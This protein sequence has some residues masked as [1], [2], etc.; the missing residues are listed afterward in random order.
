MDKSHCGSRNPL[1]LSFESPFLRRCILAAYWLL[2]LLAVPAWWRTTSIERLSLP[3]SQVLKQA[4]REIEFPLEIHLSSSVNGV[5]TGALARE[6]E[7]TLEHRLSRRL[8]VIPHGPEDI[9]VSSE[10]GSYWVKLTQDVRQS[11]IENE[12]L[13]HPWDIHDPIASSALTNSLAALLSP[14]TEQAHAEEREHVVSKYA[15]RFRIAF[16]LLNEDAASGRS[17]LSWDIREALKY[18]ILPV[19]KRLETL[20]NFTVESQVQYHAPLAFTPTTVSV[21]GT[22]VY[23]L[24]PEDL[25]VFVN[26][27]EWTL[28]SGVT[29]DPVLHF[30]MFIPSASRR[31]LHIL[32][33]AGMPTGSHSFILPQWGGVVI[34]NP[35]FETEDN[36]YLSASQL[37]HVSSIFRLQLLS[38]LGVPRLPSGVKSTSSLS[39]WQIDALLRRRAQENVR[40]AQQT[41]ES[42]VKL[43]EQIE[44]MPVGQDVKQDVEDALAALD[45]AFE[46]AALSPKLAF[47]HSARALTLA[48]RAFFNPGM[49]ALLYFPPEHRV[50][51][52]TPLFA[53]A[54]VPL[55]V[56][57][58]REVVA[59]RKQ[60][61]AAALNN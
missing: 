12:I 25:T 44:N 59:W 18:N 51:V 17:A 3:T 31:P 46:A 28:S 54:T 35:P 34:H 50:A 47:D 5:D 61:K 1:E 36:F 29:N 32:N 39:R 8:S 37:D 9:F 19:L 21:D 42:I 43:V 23:G 13:L 40:E 11:T 7:R 41:L 33:D 4:K 48:S 60:R 38:L 15:P 2:I 10:T 45:Q 56:A 26:S 53:S 27:A 20:H 14:Y 58:V 6:L 55:V 49:L 30:L 22:D 16:T 24:T 52:Y 57:V